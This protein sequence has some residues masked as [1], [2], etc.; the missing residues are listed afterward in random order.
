MLFLCL[1]FYY[2]WIE[3]HTM[4]MKYLTNSKQKHKNYRLNKTILL[5]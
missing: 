5:H 4:A 2:N 1:A 3:R